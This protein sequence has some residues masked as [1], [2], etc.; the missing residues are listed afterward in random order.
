MKK[1]LLAVLL[2]VTTGLFA[3]MKLAVISSERVMYE[4]PAAVKARDEIAKWNKLKEADAIKM[5]N[6]V[7]RMAKEIENLSVLIAPEKK[8]EKE[9]E[10]QKKYNELLAFKDRIW[11]QNGEAY[12]EQKKLLEPIMKKINDTIKIVSE[13]DG[14]DFVFDGSNGMVIFAKPTY[15]I[16]EK[17]LKE[18]TK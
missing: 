8:K 7:E 14:Y 6:E 10:A 13:R 12:K 3:E 17:I 5:Q 18:L 4:T 16:T 9:V 11:G 2:I 15:D 1:I